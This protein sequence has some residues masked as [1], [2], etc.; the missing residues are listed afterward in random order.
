[1]TLLQGDSS[2]TGEP[3]RGTEG[4]DST[5]T[6]ETADATGRLA[7]ARTRAASAAG[8][9]RGAAGTV[10]DFLES[11]L[12]ARGAV[13]AVFALLGLI[14]GAAFAW[15][16]FLAL[17]LAAL[18]LIVLAV[19]F[20]LGKGRHEVAVDL[21]NTRVVVGDPARARI[22]VSNPHTGSLAGA[23]VEMPVGRNVAAFDVP[24]LGPGEK[25]EETLVIPTQRRSVHVLGPVRTV[26]GD[27]AGL[28][29]RVQEWGG[30][31]TLYVHPRTAPL[32]RVTTGLLRDLDGVSS[33]QLASDDVAF[34]ALRPY[35]RGDDRRAV[36]WRS[37]ARTGTLMVRQYEESRRWHVGIGLSTAASD[38]ADADEFETAVSVAGS[39]GLT[40][41][42]DARSL[43]VLTQRRGLYTGAPRMLLDQL[44]GVETEPTRRDVVAL[45]S[46]LATEAPGVSLVVLVVGSTVD[47]TRL[48]TAYTRIPLGTTCVAI[49]VRPGEQPSR[50]RLGAL[51]VVSVGTLA[52]L[53]RALRGALR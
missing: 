33:D 23:T 39:I 34:H 41:L 15:T 51:L 8:S 28:L 32:D 7:A 13:V 30:R 36:H 31:E 6:S 5:A 47:V 45:A 44:S 25:V 38:Y 35:V 24:R 16:E 20:A 18:V 19:P 21:S 27:P 43:T 14:A 26:R 4:G 22:V 29:R 11:T 17:G 46:D 52:D 1:M 10:R 53:P 50:G 40:A 12:T 37:T 3:S 42:T 2:R 48:K 9:A 49:R